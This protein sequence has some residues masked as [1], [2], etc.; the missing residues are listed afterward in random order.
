MLGFLVI[1]HNHFGSGILGAAEMIVGKQKN[2]ECID[3]L[4]DFDT[5]A[6]D[7]AINQTLDKLDY[8]E[9]IVVFTDLTG[10][11]PFNRSMVAYTEKPECNIHVI[12]GTNLPILIEALN[13]RESINDPEALVKQIMETGRD[14][15][16][17]GNE[18]L[19]NEMEKKC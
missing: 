8:G 17:Y 9:G 6:L 18:I 19:K 16:V 7:N 13:L 1:G 14:N 12:S 5:A 10:G 3:F 2:I 15:I 4:P 11:S